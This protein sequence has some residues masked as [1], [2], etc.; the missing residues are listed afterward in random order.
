MGS[1]TDMALMKQSIK[2]IEEGM[3]SHNENDKKMFEKF[4]EK[5]DSIDSKLDTVM[6]KLD[7]KYAAKWTEDVMRAVGY[8]VGGIIVV[9]LMALIIVKV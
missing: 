1:D 9:A 6:E 4:D 3:K 8:T 2:G 5:F 7:K